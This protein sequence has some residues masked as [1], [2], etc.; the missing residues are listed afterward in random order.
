M[1]I[2]A[3]SKRSVSAAAI[4]AALILTLGACAG[5]SGSEGESSG[6]LTTVKVGNLVYTGTAPFQLGI[7]KGFFEEEGLKIEQIEG[8]NPATIAGQI[9]SGQLDIGFATTTFLAT[10]VAQGAPLR[11]I[12]AVDGLID[13]EKPA[14]AIVVGEDS[15]ITSP[16][17]LAGKK[18]G[19]VALGSELHLL[20]LVVVDEDGGD[21]ST[22][23]PVQLPFPQMQQALESGNVDAIVT[24]EPFLTATLDT[25]AKA[26]NYPEIEVFP[27]GSVTAW[28]SSE[29][30]INSNP[31]AVAAFSRA[32]EKTLAYSQDHKDEVLALIPD[33]AGL[34]KSQ[35]ESMNLG[36]VFDPTLD[37]DSIVEMAKLLNKYGFIDK[38]PTLDQLVYE[39]K[40]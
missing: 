10:A 8:D 31:E 4:S 5:G 35:L 1:N 14:S 13:T 9:T 11:A 37:A 32:M 30:F 21:S 29:S 38:T 20:S 36:T 17:D 12:A 18:V 6:D 22:V 33:Y 15:G 40:G 19:V 27:K 26:I 23:Q 24:T 3:R 34:D 39:A 2:R 25:G 7:K 28:I 16:K